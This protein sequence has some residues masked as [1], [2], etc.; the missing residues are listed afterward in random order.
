MNYYK[1]DKPLVINQTD[2]MPI[3]VDAGQIV[4]TDSTG[5]LG[6]CEEKDIIVVAERVDAE[7]AKNIAEAEAWKKAHPEPEPAEE[8]PV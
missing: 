3:T 2:E 1:L 4:Y 5:V 6:V 7:I 8:L